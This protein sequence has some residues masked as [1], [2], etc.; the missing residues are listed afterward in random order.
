MSARIFGNFGAEKGYIRTEWST[1]P[2]R[3][4]SN[5]FKFR[6]SAYFNFYYYANESSFPLLHQKPQRR[7]GRTLRKL[8]AEKVESRH[9]RRDL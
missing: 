5:G 9:R 6:A 3:A 1:F 7:A 2:D 8:R 4:T